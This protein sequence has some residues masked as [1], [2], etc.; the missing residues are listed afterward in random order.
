MTR[1]SPWIGYVCGITNLVASVVLVVW[2]R[3]GTEAEPD[4]AQRLR[5]IEAH[6]L[7]WQ[8]GWAMWM[9]AAL[10]LVAFFVWWNR[11]IAIPGALV[12]VDL[13]IFLAVTGLCFDGSAETLYIFLPR[14]IQAEPELLHNIQQIAST[15]SGLCANGCYCLCG[16]LLSAISWNRGILRGWL[17]RMGFLVWIA[18]LALSFFA[19]IRFVPGMIAS[20]AA[21]MTL[22][23]PWVIL[24]TRHLVRSAPPQP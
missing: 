13:P 1:P 5:Y 10:S 2:L 24:T 22:F 16:V 4:P 6:A 9:M 12:V 17:C 14:M 21:A 18:G 8:V 20:T 23:C 19:A 3:P 15:F 11:R 7:L